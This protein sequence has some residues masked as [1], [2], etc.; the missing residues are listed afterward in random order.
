MAVEYGEFPQYN[1]FEM[2]YCTS[3]SELLLRLQ[4]LKENGHLQNCAVL[5]FNKNGKLKLAYPKLVKDLKR[6]VCQLWQR[7]DI[8]TEIDGGG[9]LRKRIVL[10]VKIDAL[11]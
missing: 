3:E 6:F 11:K 7:K 10:Y 5:F 2:R 9:T 4:N 1:G 8:Q